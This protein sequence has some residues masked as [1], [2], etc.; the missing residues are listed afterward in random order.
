MHVITA[1]DRQERVCVANGVSVHYVATRM[2][3]LPGPVRRRGTGIWAL[4][5]RSFSVG[6]YLH[7]LQRSVRFDVVEATNWGAEALFF[8]LRPSAPLLVR[9]ST[10]F[11]TV[12][13][14]KGNIEY[15]RFGP[16]LH[17]R[18]EAVPVRRAS[19]VIA[20][21]QFTRGIIQREYNVPRERIR[22]VMHGLDVDAQPPVPAT[23]ELSGPIVLYVG[24]LERR[25]G[26][27]FLLQAIPAVVAAVPEV[28]FHLAGKDTG[29]A[30][31]GIDY[32]TYFAGFA[33]PAA[34][35]ATTFLGFV[36]PEALEQEYA[37]CEIFVAP[38]LFES[39]GLIHLEAMMRG[40][41]VVAFR[42]AATPEIVVDGETG[43]LVAP[44][45]SA[46]LAEALIGL[47]R[48]PETARMMGERG[49]LRAER[50]FSL[51]QMIKGSLAVYSEVAGSC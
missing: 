44:E 49:R 39:F 21:S 37:T 12:G 25:K 45:D 30:P 34:I 22:V 46:D 16:R 47:L 26:T 27:Q 13:S 1:T 31:G 23:G 40:K 50:E 29:D 24:R 48:A 35:A 3:P 17:R 18:L 14:I 8:S 51:D 2:W 11:V 4:L 9:V 41:P 5:E 28:R 42:A 7:R 36:D 43:V 6:R 15:R 20:N 19:R 32:Q 33:P 10:T 38:S